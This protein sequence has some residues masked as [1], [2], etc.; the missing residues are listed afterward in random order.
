MDTS[1]IQWVCLLGVAILVGLASLPIVIKRRK[2]LKIYWGRRCTG[3][4]WRSRFPEADTEDIRR[5]LQV[6][7]DGFAFR[8]RW[9]LKFSPDDDI[10]DIYRALNPERG[11]PDAMELETLTEMLQQEYGIDLAKLWREGMTLGSV[12]ELTQERKSQ[13]NGEA[14]SRS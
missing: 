6:F 12:F 5:F 9:R 11:W 1:K 14:K 13:P 10:M 7:V 8:E 3:K 2:A 4:L